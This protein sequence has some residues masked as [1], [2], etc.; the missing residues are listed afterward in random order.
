[1]HVMFIGFRLVFL[2]YFY[3]VFN[4]SA[5]VF[6]SLHCYKAADMID[7]IKEAKGKIKGI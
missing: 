2:K 7:H 1:M 6:V 3:L 4:A 5:A